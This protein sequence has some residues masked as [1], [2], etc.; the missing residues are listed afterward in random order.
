MEINTTMHKLIENGMRRF[1]KHLTRPQMKAVKSVTRGIIRKT[2]TILS[3]LNEDAELT[4]RKYRER[5]SYHLG[6]ID[7][8]DEV[9]AK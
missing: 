8:V 9:E 1:Q 5:I 7:L 2:T 3:A 6:N 4:N